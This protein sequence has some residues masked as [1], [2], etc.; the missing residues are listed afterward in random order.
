MIFFF[1]CFF[2]WICLIF[3]LFWLMKIS[4]T[5]LK[6]R[7]KKQGF[8]YN[9]SIQ[10]AIKSKNKIIKPQFCSLKIVRAKQKLFVHKK[11][12]KSHLL[13]CY[14]IIAFFFYIDLLLVIVNIIWVFIVMIQFC[15]SK[16]FSFNNFNSLKTT[17]NFRQLNCV[18][19]WWTMDIKIKITLNQKDFDH[20]WILLIIWNLI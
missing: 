7:P 8:V 6:Q 11:K 12:K 1:F 4:T 3:L 16:R 17:I 2:L 9:R 18:Y 13:M 15:W 14:Y 5:K 10:I 20:D 19:E